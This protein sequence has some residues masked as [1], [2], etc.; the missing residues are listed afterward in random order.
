MIRYN[1]IFVLVIRFWFVGCADDRGSRVTAWGLWV[2]TSRDLMRRVGWVIYW[3][4]WIRS[5]SPLSFRYGISLNYN[6]LFFIIII[7]SYIYQ[8]STNDNGFDLVSMPYSSSVPNIREAAL[9]G[10]VFGWLVGAVVFYILGMCIIRY[11]FKW[12][13]R[14]SN[15]SSS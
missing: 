9:I 13:T 11:I 1:R 3:R 8:M 12:Q 7:W 5:L 10:I 2:R 6:Y 14:K 15:S 4:R